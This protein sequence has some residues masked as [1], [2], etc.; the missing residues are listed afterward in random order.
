MSAPYPGAQSRPQAKSEEAPSRAG[1][2]S[3]YA[4]PTLRVH[5]DVAALTQRNW[6][7]PGRQDG[8]NW[9]RRTG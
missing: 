9:F 8:S 3:A 6:W 5:G 2:R 1:G 4:A 7:A